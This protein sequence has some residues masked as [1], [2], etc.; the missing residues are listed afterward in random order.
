MSRSGQV[1]ARSGKGELASALHR[2][3]EAEL[4]V[5][6]A[7]VATIE[8]A[9][10]EWELGPRAA[11]W[12]EADTAHRARSARDHR[13]VVLSFPPDLIARRTGWVETTGFL[14]DLVGRIAAVDEP[15]RRDRLVSV[16]VDEL[17]AAP[18]APPALLDRV[19]ALVRAEPAL[20]AAAIASRLGL[21]ERALRR[22]FRE[23]VGTS[24]RRWH[25]ERLVACATERLGR[26]ESVKRVAA[27]LGYAN[28]SAF[29]AMY[30][31]VTGTTPGTRRRP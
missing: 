18:V 17:A 25:Q 7:G 20:G 12:L 15:A 29:I 27:D 3:R 28:P 1:V 10:A 22:S 26:G 16:L 9:D 31:R 21:S 5:G 8:T 2:H 13:A 30:K 4:V 19:V 11:L 23:D 24:F 6:I 14:H